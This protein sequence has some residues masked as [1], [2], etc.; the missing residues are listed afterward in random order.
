MSYFSYVVDI[1]S[2]SP[3]NSLGSLSSS[4][5]YRPT[6][7]TTPTDLEDIGKK[8]KSLHVLNI[9]NVDRTF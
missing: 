7:S 4:T 8:H 9:N 1:E 2:W 6:T 5:V 3:S